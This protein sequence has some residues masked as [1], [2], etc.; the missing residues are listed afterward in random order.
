MLRTRLWMGTILVL[1]TAGLLALDQLVSPP[2]HYFLFM[3]VLCV[4]MAAVVELIHLLG[5]MQCV[6]GLLLVAGVPI[7]AASNYWRPWIAL[8]S[9]GD[10]VPGATS[11]ALGTFVALVFAVF[12]WEMAT[13]L[14]VR[15]TPMEV[16]GSIDRMGRTIWVIAYLGF[17]PSF[18]L[19]LPW[20]YPWEE[21]E[22][23]NV[24][25]AL[26]IFVP[27][28]CDIG[29][30]CTGRLLGRHPMTPV[31]SP[32]KTWEG[33]V[34]GLTLGTLT[35]IGIDQWGPVPLLGRC[36]GREIGFG[37][38]LGIAGMLGDLAESLVKRA[39]RRKDASAVVPGFG[40]VLDVVDAVIF[41]AP[42]GYLWL[43]SLV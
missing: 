36:L 24:A 8:L 38:T 13:F 2:S 27:K 6:Q 28:C 43:G 37:L 11:L 18:L 15:E 23:G 22:Y 40:G 20:L 35:A 30:Y 12:I 5:G 16:N 19:A 17:L 29:A 26:V 32:K 9:G 21:A 10:W 3:T 1:V 14:P 33:A 39:C 34:G 41:A 42:V 31:L 4:S 7:L 25:L